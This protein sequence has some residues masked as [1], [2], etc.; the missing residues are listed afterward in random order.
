MVES[1]KDE[2]LVVKRRK[3][4]K[5]FKVRNVRPE[6]PVRTYED[7]VLNKQRIAD[8][9]INRNME[10][11]GMNITLKECEEWLSNH[12]ITP[13]VKRVSKKLG[14]QFLEVKEVKWLRDDQFAKIMIIFDRSGIYHL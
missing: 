2:K 13:E 4:K 11:F 7:K 8:N 6:R 12:E 9:A 14:D 3:K 10:K 5:V 1:K